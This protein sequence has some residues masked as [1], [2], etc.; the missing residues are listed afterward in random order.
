MLQVRKILNRIFE[1]R[2]GEH[3]RTFLMFS[4]LFLTIASYITTS[5]ARDGLF[6]KKLGSHQLPYVYIL[7]ALV[8]GVIS[9]FYLRFAN[10]VSLNQLIRYTSVVA[11]FNLLLFWWAPRI[12]GAW[13]YY[14]M[15]IW[16]SLFGAFTTSQFWLLANYAF[17]PREAKRLFALIG[18]G[19]VLGGIFGGAF[20]TYGAR[21]FGTEQLLLWSA[22]FT[23]VSMLLAEKVW[24]E[25]TPPSEVKLAREENLQTPPQKA[26]T[27]QL[28]KM[29]LSSRHLTLL[30]AVLSITVIIDAFTDY[31]LKYISNQSIDTSDQ[32]TSFFGTLTVYRGVLSFFVQVFVTPLI[33]KRFGVG[34]AILFLPGSLLLGS[35]ILALYPVRW[36]VALMKVSDGSFRFSIHRSGIEL[37]YLPIPVKVK[38]QVKGFIDIFI[39]RFGVGVGGLLLLVCTSWLALSITQLSLIVCALVSIWIGACL[40]IRREYVNS[41]RLALE[42]KIIQPEDLRVRISDSGMLD[43]LTRFLESTDERL[44]LYALRLLADSSSDSWVKKVPSLLN[45]S[46]ARVR[47]L[48]IESLSRRPAKELE[49]SVRDRLKDPDLEVRSE[50]I[51]YLCRE[52]ESHSSERI[53]QFLHES[54][55]AVVGAAVHSMAKYHIPSHQMIDEEFIQGAM[56][57][58]GAQREPARVAAACAL[59]LIPAD[60]RLQRYLPLLLE[61]PSKEV[62][63]NAIRSAGQLTSPEMPPRLVQ[64]L[65]EPALRAEAREALLNYGFSIVPILADRLGDT[66]APTAVRVNIPK[67]LALLGTQEAVDALFHNLQQT[68]QF[69]SYRVIKALNQIRVRHPEL[70]FKHEVIDDLVV[71]ELKN[72][73]RFALA[74]HSLETNGSQEHRV[75]KLLHR[76]LQEHLDQKLEE[77]FRLLGLRY[78]PRDMLVAYNGIRSSQSALRGSAIEFLDNLLQPDFKRLLFPILEASSLASFAGKADRRLF[79]FPEKSNSAYLRYLIQGRDAWLKTIAIYAVGSF[80]LSELAPLIRETLDL[81]DPFMSQTAQWS[82]SQLNP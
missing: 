20:T 74:L 2:E 10:R 37:L 52:E 41:F 28:L 27:L 53:S 32:L 19:G 39:D 26:E 64:M 73:Y 11:I 66:A 16:V 59:G 47:A 25:V 79:S 80:K 81:A 42:K 29:I 46:S 61:D 5:L 33:L 48:A 40:I 50:A 12:S 68:D 72:Y 18:A 65:A 57:Q 8:V 38:N 69:L 54:D 14:V 82:W 9:P 76:T 22:G 60:S 49:L 4:C 78:P 30:T 67:V 21:W 7:I 71:E 15:Y 31:Q 56:A 13:L 17:N 23:A 55:Y 62:V 43:S 24:S 3:L 44:V 75:I 51:H 35:A 70:S 77:V 6:L 63:R 1:I 34:V 36:A 58:Q 45:H